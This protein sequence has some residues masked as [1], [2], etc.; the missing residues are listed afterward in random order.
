MT[1]RSVLLLFC[2][3]L[4]LLSLFGKRSLVEIYRLT[5][6]S[7]ELRQEI[8]RLQTSNAALSRDILSLRS[9]PTRVEEI[10]RHDLGMVRPG[11]IVYEFAPS[12]AP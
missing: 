3:A 7:E 11:E 2:G 6:L 9:D 12:P 5:R 8:T 1:R 10:A 4:T